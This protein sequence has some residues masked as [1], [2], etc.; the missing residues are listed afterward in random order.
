MI[1][2][3]ILLYNH[4]ISPIYLSSYGLLSGRLHVRAVV[5]QGDIRVSQ[6]RGLREPKGS[7][8]VIQGF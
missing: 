3:I 5:F 2:V 4:Y 8:G 1:P 6:K 7:I